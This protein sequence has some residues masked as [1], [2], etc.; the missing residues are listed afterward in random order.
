MRVRVRIRTLVIVMV[1]GLMVIGIIAVGI[2]VFASSHQSD[3]DTAAMRALIAR[4]L[5]RGASAAAVTRFV[6]S[7]DFLVIQH[8]LRFDS[9]YADARPVPMATS[10]SN[11]PADPSLDPS[12][13][14]MRI[15]LDRNGDDAKMDVTFV[16]DGRGR[17]VRSV[18]DE[19]F[20][21][22]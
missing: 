22:I 19:F 21:T 4:D 8:T 14:V 7:S 3:H 9:V 18:V 10:L 5:G 13:V 20:P 17:Y 15:E 6:H 12:A 2:L 1:V 11:L 16:F